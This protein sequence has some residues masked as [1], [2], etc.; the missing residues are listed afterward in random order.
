VKNAATVAY[1]RLLMTAA[2]PTKE[3]TE[4]T[5][6]SLTKSSADGQTIR[7]NGNNETVT[8]AP[9]KDRLAKEC[10]GDSD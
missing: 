3:A 5:G 10:Y 7:M 6:I 8:L 1:R 4:G 2:M 9:K